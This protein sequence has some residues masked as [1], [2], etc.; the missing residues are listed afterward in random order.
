M[1]LL[2][3]LLEQARQQGMLTKAPNLP[4]V[5]GPDW[6][7]EVLL[8]HLHTTRCRNCGWEYET[9]M[10]TRLRLRD[11]KDPISLWDIVQPTMNFPKDIHRDI[12]ETSDTIPV[13]SACFHIADTDKCIDRPQVQLAAHP[14]SDDVISAHAAMHARPK[15][16]ITLEDL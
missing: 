10:G 11:R 9:P 15:T 8:L 5:S 7:P 14:H 13:C 6:Y 4:R 16:A 12:Y 3:D 2:D 1:G